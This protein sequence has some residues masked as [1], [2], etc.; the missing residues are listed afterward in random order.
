MNTWL[1]II[2]EC[3]LPNDP[4]DFFPVVGRNSGNDL[5]LYLGGGRVDTGSN[6]GSFVAFLRFPKRMRE[7]HIFLPITNDFLLPNTYPVAVRFK[8]FVS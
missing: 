6:I 1:T 5:D 3:A 4:D 8:F 7:K 2:V